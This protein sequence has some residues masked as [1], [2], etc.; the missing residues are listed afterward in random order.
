M[1]TAWRAQS[2]TGPARATRLKRRLGYVGWM[3][4]VEGIRTA[5]PYL[6]GALAGALVTVVVMRPL[7]RPLPPSLSLPA[8]PPAAAT[9]PV[10][11]AIDSAG[12]AAAVT[13]GLSWIAEAQQSSVAG[14]LDPGRFT[15]RYFDDRGIA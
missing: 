14:A 1:A 11:P 4:H 3:V 12:A 6:L 2:I 9:P 13:R 15:P 10:A 7:L 5:T 8:M